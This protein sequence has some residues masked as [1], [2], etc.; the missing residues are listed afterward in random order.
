MYFVYH[1]FVFSFAV[2]YVMTWASLSIKWSSWRGLKSVMKS[3]LNFLPHACFPCCVFFQCN[4]SSYALCQVISRFECRVLAIKFTYA[5]YSAQKLDYYCCCFVII[6]IEIQVLYIVLFLY[7]ANSIVLL[8]NT[9]KR[10]LPRCGVITG[11]IEWAKKK[12]KIKINK[13]L[14]TLWQLDSC[15]AI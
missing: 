9:K 1:C 13:F 11:C 10:K 6:Y 2:K 7:L 15:W 14:K 12:K 4:Y 5:N 3:C 8:L